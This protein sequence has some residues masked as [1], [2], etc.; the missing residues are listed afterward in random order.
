MTRLFVAAIIYLTITVVL[1]TYRAVKGP[2]PEDRLIA[3]NVIGTKTAVLIAIVSFILKETYFLDVALVYALISFMAS[4]VIA[5]TLEKRG[6]PV[7]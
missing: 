1:C 6:G 5:D 3:V 7:D 4:M 2:S